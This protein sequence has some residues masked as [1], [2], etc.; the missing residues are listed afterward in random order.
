M[1]AE[2]LDLVFRLTMNIVKFESKQG[3]WLFVEDIGA[4]YRLIREE[5]GIDMQTVADETKIQKKFLQAIEENQW[6]ALPGEVYL[7]GFLRIYAKYL[8]IDGQEIIDIY[9]SSKQK[10]HVVIETFKERNMKSALIGAGLFIILLLLGVLT[11][12]LLVVP[13]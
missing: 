3:W 9:N 13:S 7:R 10:D 1:L 2:V 12:Y 5:K 4:K 8:G 6:E 11:Y